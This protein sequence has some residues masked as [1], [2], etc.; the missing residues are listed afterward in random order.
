MQRNMSNQAD[1]S[2]PALHRFSAAVDALSASMHQTRRPSG[3]CSQRTLLAEGFWIERRTVSGAINAS[4]EDVCVAIVQN[5]G[6]SAKV[7]WTPTEDNILTS[8][9]VGIS[10]F[11]RSD[12]ASEMLWHDWCYVTGNDGPFIIEYCWTAFQAVRPRP[13]IRNFQV[14]VVGDWYLAYPEICT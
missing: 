1:L 9:G 2:G 4:H 13:F 11:N 8:I 12:L 6:S 7:E 14:D 3:V 5:E 10:L